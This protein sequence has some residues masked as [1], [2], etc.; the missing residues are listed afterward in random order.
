MSHLLFADQPC[1][2][3]APG[4]FE[5]SSAVNAVYTVGR[6]H[7]GRALENLLNDNRVLAGDIETF[8]LGVAARR[9]K[10]VQF[11]DGHRSVVLDPRDPYQAEW[12]RRVFASLSEVVFHNSP[13]DIPNL[14]LNNLL[15]IEDVKKV[16]DTLIWCRLAEPGETVPKSLEAASN[17]YLSTGPGGELARAFAMLGL[18]KKDGF[19]TFDLDRPIYVQGAASDPLM[20][21]RL[22][23]N[24]KE[25]ALARITTD[26]PFPTRGLT[27]TEA[28][29]LLWREQRINRRITLPR[30]CRGFRVDFEFAEQ[31]AESNAVELREAETELAALGIRPGSGPD[32]ARVLEERGEMPADFPRTQKTGAYSMTAP[33]VEKLAS[34]VARKFVRQKQ[35]KKIGSDYISKVI[36]LAHNGRVHSQVNLLAA[37][38]G[39]MSMGEPPFQQFSGPARGIVLADH[40]DQLTSVDLSQGEPVTIANAAHD[41]GVL[42]GYE[43]GTSDLYT[44]LGV[45]AGMLPAGTTTL[46]CELDP[47]KKAIRKKLKAALLAQ[48]YGQGLPLLTA[49]LGLDDG[50][51]GPPTDWEVERMGHDPGQLYPRYQE[52][53]YLRAQVFAAMPETEK[54]IGTL[55]RLGAKYGKMITIAGRVLDIPYS[56]KFHRYEVHKAVNYFCQGGQYDLIADAL[57]RIID[58]GL[59]DSVYLVLHDEIVASTSASRDIRAILEKPSERLCFW[60]KREPVLRT[61]LK[62]LGERWADA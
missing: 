43:A 36:D 31:Y 38:T 44:E 17:R 2:I 25:A 62:D 22:A 40:G 39:R 1:R 48:L 3:E 4:T 18:S 12:V 50:P 6:D 35:I 15:R 24:V 41:M 54:F 47:A 7:V 23:E 16:T 53:A 8:G 27:H 33:N 57:I 30:T 11:G 59:E 56:Q 49:Q 51:Y 58:A 45:R 26:N 5:F 10:S 14:Y 55:K 52:A 37:A 9:L 32:L 46:D 28:H 42:V 13:F 34:P 60:A 20:T 21:F 19:K 29:N 61:D